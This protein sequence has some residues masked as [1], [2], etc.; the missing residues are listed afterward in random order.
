M[1]LSTSNV[2]QFL[3]V[4]HSVYCTAGGGTFK[5]EVV[6]QRGKYRILSWIIDDYEVTIPRYGRKTKPKVCD[7]QLATANDG[8]FKI[9]SNEVFSSL[10]AAK[11]SIKKR[12]AAH[13]P[14]V[15]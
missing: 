1:Q 5:F 9:R 4:V 2:V 6:K 14:K 12:M 10:S 11:A 7:V 13:F 15:Q 8:A 3:E